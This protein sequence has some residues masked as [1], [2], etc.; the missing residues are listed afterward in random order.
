MRPLFFVLGLAFVATVPTN[1]LKCYYEDPHVPY[2]TV[3]CGDQE[4]KDGWPVG[5][6]KQCV[7]ANATNG[8]D[9]MTLRYGTFT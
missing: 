6:Y 1:G 3:D 5:T 2:H 7:T 9:K 8:R 4:I